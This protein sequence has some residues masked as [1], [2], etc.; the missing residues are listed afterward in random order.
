MEDSDREVKRLLIIKRSHVM[1]RH[2][3]SPEGIYRCLTSYIILSPLLFRPCLVSN[4][5]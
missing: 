2:L 3:A 4:L 5:S 1:P